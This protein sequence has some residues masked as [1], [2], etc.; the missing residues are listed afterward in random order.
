MASAAEQQIARELSLGVQQVTAIAALLAEGATVPFIARYRKEATGSCDEVQ[1]AAVRDGLERLAALEKRRQSILSSLAE[2]DLLTPDVQAQM[3]AAADLTTLEDLYLPHRPKRRTRAGIARE[4][5]LEP[6]AE[7]IVRGDA[8]LRPEQFVD[9]AKE[10]P[11]IETALAGARDI[12]AEGISE[13][14]ALRQELRSWY[15]QQ[16]QLTGSVIAKRKDDAEAAKFRDWFG[17]REALAKAPSH[18]ILAL[19]RGAE[20]KILR[21]SASVDDERAK[22]LVQR[23]CC[24]TRRSAEADAQLRLA[25]DEAWARLL[26]PSLAN[27]ALGAAK[28]RAD[29]EA[30][31]IFQ[32]NMRE[33]LLAAPLGRQRVLAI[34][35]GLRTGCKV[36]AL[37]ER[38]ELLAHEILHLA[39][40]RSHSRDLQRLSALVQQFA[41]QAIAVGNGTGSREAEAQIRAAG[42]GLPIC[43]VDESGASIYSASAV[44][45]EEFPDH[46]LTVRGAVSIGRRLQDPLAELVKLD[47][48]SIGVGQYQHDVDQAALQ[49]SLDDAVMSCV[50]Q[51]GVEL[52]SASAQ[53][54]SYVSGLGPKLAQAVVSFRREQGGFRS[55][56]QLLKVPRLGAKAFEQCAGFLRVEDSKNPLDAS[57]VH[58]ERYAL[59]EA[60][61]QDQGVGLAQLLASPA[62]R[63]A[64]DIRRYTNASVGEPTLRDIMS[65]LD[66]PGRDPRPAFT[67][68]TFADVHSLDDLVQDQVLPG[69]VTNVTAFGAFVDLGVHQDGLVHISQLSDRF[70]K[71]PNDVVKVRQTVKVRV[72]EVDRARKRIALSM[73]GVAQ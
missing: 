40:E 70:I 8:A 34:D 13:D 29:R 4:R 14:A 16:A 58:P 30:I 38:G 18:R 59:V 68:F 43:V 17:W 20:Q 7:A 23:H 6:L 32:N 54:L 73:R 36:V 46:D 11:D 67:T 21:V 27:E 48:K 1:I 61:A 10:V 2:R 51:V 15:A 64:I 33:L 35:P 53:L 25:C 66:K 57:A 69:I 72:M 50:N 5:G 44:A 31:A 37:D 26:Q 12:L 41:I 65:E 47:P 62:L 19:L 24:R 39:T 63:Q 42:L 49:R 60:M 28:E 22:A 56:A 55:R 9:A 45:R 71:D 3:L 52:N